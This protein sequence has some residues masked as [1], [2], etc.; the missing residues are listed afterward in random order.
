MHSATDSLSV[1][2]AERE[3]ALA[4]SPRPLSVPDVLV[5]GSLYLAPCRI[6]SRMRAESANCEIVFCGELFAFCRSES[7]DFLHFHRTAVCDEEP[8]KSILN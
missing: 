1:I 5:I 6:Q 8:Q 3:D 7:I 4:A 2:L